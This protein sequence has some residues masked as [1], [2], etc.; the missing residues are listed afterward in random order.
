MKAS[1]GAILCDLWHTSR[2]IHAAHAL[3]QLAEQTVRTHALKCNVMM[4]FSVLRFFGFAIFNWLVL[5][6]GIYFAYQ[7]YKSF[8]AQP[9][10]VQASERVDDELAAATA[11]RKIPRPKSTQRRRLFSPRDLSTGERGQ[12]SVQPFFVWA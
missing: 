11:V 3:L 1:F 9:S 5:G 4:P 7:T 10:E 2:R 12:C 6:A 8:N